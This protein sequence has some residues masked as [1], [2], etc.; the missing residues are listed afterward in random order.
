MKALDRKVLRDLRLLWSQALTIALVVASGIGGFIACLSA[1][2]SLALARDGFYAAGHFADVFA[3]VKRA[4]DALGQRLREVPGIVDVQTT[5]ESG[6]RVTLPTTLDP[7]IGQIIGLD[8]RHAPHLNL[9][10]LRTGRR[11]EA[12]TRAGGELEALVS[13][14]F[15]N[16][17]GLKVGSQ[18][19]AL[20]NGKRRPLRITGIALSPEYIFAGLWGMP[21]LRAFGVFWVDKDELAAAL[22]MT[23]AFN[24]LALKLAP[25]AS[26]RAVDD[27]V[28]RILAPLGGTPAHG[29]D[30]Q[31]SHSM[32]DNEIREQ[33]VLG[34]ILPAIFLAVA[35]FLLHVVTARLV[36]TQRE[37]VAALKALGYGNRSIAL[38]YLKLVAPMVG[39]GYLLGM[40]LGDWLGSALMGLYAEVF[41]FPVFEHHVSAQLAWIG[42]GIV[43]VTA[44]LGTLTAIGATVRLS[45]AEAMRPPAPGRYRRALLERLPWLRAGTAL[46]MILRNIE[47]R[48]LRAALTTGGIASAVAIVIMGNFF[49]DAIEVIVDANFTLAMRGDIALWTTDVV[50][51]AA[52]RELAR[53]PGVLQVDAGRGVAVRFLHGQHSEKGAIQGYADPAELRRIIDVDL[54]VNAPGT[55]G[56]V[57]TDRLADKLGLRVGD[58]VTV[59]AR[60]GRRAVR[61]VVVEATVRDMMGLNAFMDRRA[62]NRLLGDGDVASLFTLSIERGAVKSVLDAT[63][64]M[65]RVAGT[66][67]KATMLRNMQEITAR[68][69]RVTSTI[70]TLFAVVIAVGVVY[71]NARIALAE[72]SWEL[73]SLRV[74]GFTRREVSVLL[75]GELALGIAIALP[76]GMALGW[77]MTHS[78]VGLMRNDQFMFPVVIR[79][80]TYAWAALAV[81]IAGVASAMVV[82]RRIDR[83]DMVGALKTRE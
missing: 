14:G 50:D 34:T 51:A 76:V 32:L 54:H 20:M 48:P 13:E 18:V 44:V 2:D 52:A 11:P 27:A 10:T 60:E 57:M 78:L 33:Q 81:V 31:V 80:R 1:V 61:D 30:E 45:P 37:Q 75:L 8:A 43:S 4:P 65:P 47:R 9:V 71:N 16:A 23:G 15:A 35:G 36:A 66:F 59:E 53:I 82:R 58:T 55:D 83:L 79:A 64:E 67:A 12:G 29:R 19:S 74:L 26:E 77:V 22:D 39:G 56:I 42:L 41:R 3:A 69:I 68:N 62:L 17:H 7:V 21:D 63:Q 49:R 72:R 70:L 28:T 24:H 38:H 73:A 46:R 40:A 25:G 5:V 6:A